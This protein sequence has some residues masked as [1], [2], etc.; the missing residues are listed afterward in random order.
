MSQTVILHS[1]KSVIP[2]IGYGAGTKWYTGNNS[3]PIDKG[4]V[5]SIHEALALGYRHLDAAEM[6]GTDTS[7]A[8]AL[9]TQSIPRNEIFITSKVYRSIPNIEQACLDS[10]S[11]LGLEYLDLWL[12]HAPFFDRNKISLADAWKQMEKLVDDGKVKAI[13]VSNF[14]KKH[15]EELLALNP[16]IKP[17]VNQIEFH[18]YVYEATR[19]IIEFCKSNQIAIES[20]S[21]LGSIAYKP[22]GPVD[23]VVENLAKKYNRSSAQ[24]LLK[25][26]LIKGDIAV[27]TSSKR[28]RL[29]DFLKALDEN[30]QLTEDEMKSIDEA[31]AKLHFRK[32]WTTEID[33][34]K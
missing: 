1:S 5:Q 21:P 23:E 17:A 24:I 32:Y 34:K 6:Y 27:T 20:Y 10:L 25:W 8:E 7:I 4:L 33:G 3:A 18:P 31:G 19:E 22:G 29:E 26:N 2:R 16:R 30:F 11:R 28:E 12:I 13:G 9:R 15:L 14:Q